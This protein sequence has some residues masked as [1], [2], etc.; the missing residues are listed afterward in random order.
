MGKEKPTLSLCGSAPDVRSARAAFMP[1]GM[2]LS[3]WISRRLANDMELRRPDWKGEQ[4]VHLLPGAGQR[5]RPRAAEEVR[6]NPEAEDPA[7]IR[8][9][10]SDTLPDT[11]LLPIE[12]ELRQELID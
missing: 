12:L 10:F 1:L 9:T 3:M 8:D 2:S 4:V 5:C 11:E 7:S 6:A